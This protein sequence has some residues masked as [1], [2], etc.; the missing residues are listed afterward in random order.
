MDP[1]KRGLLKNAIQ[2]ADEE[3]RPLWA[4]GTGV[5]TSWAVYNA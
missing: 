1:E 5:C 4:N 2:A 3:L